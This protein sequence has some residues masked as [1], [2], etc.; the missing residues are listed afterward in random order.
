MDAMQGYYLIELKFYAA[1]RRKVLCS[2][3]FIL[4]L[5]T[6]FLWCFCCRKFTYFLL[7]VLCALWFIPVCLMYMVKRSSCDIDLSS[8]S[9]SF[10]FPSSLVLVSFSLY[11]FLF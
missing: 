8:S 11:F 5:F 1:E 10:F 4:S 3:P 6:Y 9:V 7:F 2:G